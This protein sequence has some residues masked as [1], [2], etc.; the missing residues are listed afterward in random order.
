V[1]AREVEA[2]LYPADESPGVSPNRREPLAVRN[3]SFNKP[4]AQVQ[5]QSIYL[6]NLRN[7]DLVG[8]HNKNDLNMLTWIIRETIGSYI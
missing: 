4:S 8:V 2:P 1:I 6:A 3:K 5:R 7:P